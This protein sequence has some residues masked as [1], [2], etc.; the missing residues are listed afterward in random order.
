[1]P[2][3]RAAF[4]PAAIVGSPAARNDAKTMRPIVL[5]VTPPDRSKRCKRVRSEMRVVR[6]GRAETA[7]GRSTK[8]RHC[9][10]VFWRTIFFCPLPAVPFA[11]SSRACRAALRPRKA[12][13]LGIPHRL[14]KKQEQIH[15]TRRDPTLVWSPIRIQG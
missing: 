10:A 15:V 11:C 9:P 3:P 13:R 4:W 14:L 5:Y 8:I 12:P 1:M 2:T 6:H 7:P